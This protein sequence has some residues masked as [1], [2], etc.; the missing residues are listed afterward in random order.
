MNTRDVNGNVHMVS[1][2]KPFYC[3]NNRQYL[4]FILVSI[5]ADLHISGIFNGKL[6]F[7]CRMGTRGPFKYKDHICKYK[8][9]HY[10]DKTSNHDKGNAYM[11]SWY[12]YIQNIILSI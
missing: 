5:D 10:K 6:L 9:F 4:D 8:Y 11:V 7:S 2:N 12:L 1:P 3:A